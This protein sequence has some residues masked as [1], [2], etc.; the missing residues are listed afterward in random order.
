MVINIFSCTAQDTKP[1]ELHPHHS[2]QPSVTPVPRDPAPFSGLQGASQ[3]HVVYRYKGSQCTPISIFKKTYSCLRYQS[4]LQSLFIQSHWLSM[5]PVLP[6]P[7]PFV[8]KWSRTMLSMPARHRHSG[9]F[10]HHLSLS[11]PGTYCF[12]QTGYPES[13]Q[14]GPVFLPSTVT[15]RE[16]WT[17]VLMLTQGALYKP[18][19]SSSILKRLP[20]SFAWSLGT[21]HAEAI[22][23]VFAAVTGYS[24]F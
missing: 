4:V 2:W 14:D 1:K 7:K 22:S 9:I 5:E 10:L 8:C 13:L 11:K 6:L 21:K 15:S 16:G 19:S 12:G 23:K 18:I 24:S 20:L 17:L 3:A